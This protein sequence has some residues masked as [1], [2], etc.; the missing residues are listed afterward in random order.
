M[1]GRTF[2]VHQIFL[3]EIIE[4]TNYIIEEDSQFARKIKEK[5]RNNAELDPTSLECE[6]G[7]ADVLVQSAPAPKDCVRDEMLTLPQLLAR[8][9]GMNEMHG[10]VI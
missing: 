7:T 9:N 10:H 3:D 6:L 4:R 1:T 2:P 5:K 8:Y